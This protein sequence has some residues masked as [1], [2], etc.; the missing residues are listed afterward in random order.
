MSRRVITDTWRRLP[1][2][3]CVHLEPPMVVTSCRV[4]GSRRIV[5]GC[6]SLRV[7]AAPDGA[8]AASSRRCR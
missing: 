4:T 7:G 6:W 8:T 2:T 1:H 5:R 3:V